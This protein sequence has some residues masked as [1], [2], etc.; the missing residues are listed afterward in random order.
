[1]KNKEINK[2]SP[3]IKKLLRN[4]SG[5]KYSTNYYSDIG[6]DSL[7]VLKNVF[8]ID[9]SYLGDYLVRFLMKKKSLFKNK[10][11]LDLG[12]GCGI[13]GIICA[14]NG[15]RKITFS[16]INPIA[17]KNSKI[18]CKIS[19]IKNAKFIES[20]LLDNHPKKDYDVII[21]NAPAISG[22][23]KNNYEASFIRENKLMLEFFNIFPRYLRK[24]GILIMPGSTKFNK[25]YSPLS[26][27]R[28]NK[29]KYLTIDKHY[30][31][32]KDYRYVVSIK[33]P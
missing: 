3:E 15:A 8:R 22:V 14:L 4:L 21:F 32:E 31:E 33:Q 1:M 20:S 28:M 5:P 29:Y 6:I 23:P 27:A 18:N 17:I 25:D 10:N 12:C 16:D 11:V 30:G 13:L 26:L 2:N 9:K 24:N 19:D 7:I